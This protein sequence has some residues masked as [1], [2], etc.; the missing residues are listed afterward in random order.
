MYLVK[1]QYP[2]CSIIC[3]RQIEDKKDAEEYV[4]DL[5]SIGCKAWIRSE[6]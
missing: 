5:L 2:N 3:E 4:H 1:F 6:C